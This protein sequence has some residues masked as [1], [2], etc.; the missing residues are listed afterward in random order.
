[1][2]NKG[3]TLV[4]LVV[5]IMIL[6]II[7]G[8]AISMVT[9]E[10]GI[11]NKAKTA[12]ESYDSSADIENNK[13]SKLNDIISGNSRGESAN[14]ES[15]IITNCDFEI[16]NIGSSSVSVKINVTATD[17]TQILGYHIFVVSKA[18]SK[19][20]A[21]MTVNQTY[22]ITG[23][24]KLT[25]Y[26]IYVKAYDIY[27]NY[28]KSQSKDFK[29]NN[30]DYLFNN[31]DVC[32]SLTGGWTGYYS[33][34]TNPGVGKFQIADTLSAET[35]GTWCGYLVRTIN[36]IDFTNYSKLVIK[37]TYRYSNSGTY[38]TS[39]SGILNSSLG[40]WIKDDSVNGV[41]ELNN[42]VRV[43]D[44]S[45]IKEKGYVSITACNGAKVSVSEVYL[46]K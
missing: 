36:Q 41:I 29:T 20:I 14:T 15:S 3:I 21:N 22:Q 37:Y 17:T 32:S 18:D 46:E 13:L 1:M 27:D 5:T 26:T 11:L 42:E 33:G 38:A 19:M 40:A 44:I 12:K 31:G 4:A 7:S 45:Q 30:S 9:S 25:D 6:L 34:G 10:N 43:I 16:T 28:N 23:L 24:S 2:R 39:Y 8:I 35:W